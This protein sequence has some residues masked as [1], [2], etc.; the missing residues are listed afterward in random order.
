[1]LSSPISPLDMIGRL[2]GYATVSS[3]SNLVLI[4]FA[5]DYLDSLG[6]QSRLSFDDDR[7]KANLFATIGPDRAGG[8]VLSGHTDVVPV[9]GQPWQSDP[10]CVDRRGE[11]IYGRG[12][13]DMKSFI[14]VA[15]STVPFFLS[16]GLRRPI[17]IELSYDEEVGCLG[18]PRML[19]DI[20]AHLPRPA[21]AIVGEPTSMQVANRHKGALAFR[22]IL[23]GRDGHSSAPQRGLNAIVFASEF[24]S[25]V[26]QMAEDYRMQGPF[27]QSFD[28]PYMTF[29]VGVIRGGTAANIIARSCEIV[30]DFR[31]LPGVDSATVIQRVKRF[32]NESLLTRMR[33]QVPDA[34]IEMAPLYHVPP[35]RPETD[36][37]TEALIRLLT[38][39][40]NS[41]GVAFTSEGGQFQQEGIPAVVFGPGNIEQAH[42]P[43][44]YITL[45]Q[46]DA[47]KQ[48]MERLAAWAASPAAG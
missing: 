1:M 18:A 12:T 15:L 3:D 41:V 17:H 7:R 24:V 32:L 38:D 20:V 8:I 13:S 29:N 22:T 25:F 23:T 39:T 6:I 30:W 9:E 4:D 45:D 48:F 31:P 36:S 14:A 47:C 33:E 35:L 40:S 26:A 43:N 10:F 2:V 19:R 27:D 16:V 21:L 28:P 5:R 11:R 44:E 42:Q 37:P 46:V 34:A